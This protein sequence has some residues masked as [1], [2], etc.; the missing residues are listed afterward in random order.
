MS[1]SPL[2]EFL[3][4]S[5]FDIVSATRL[6]HTNSQN[7]FY[8]YHLYPERQLRTEELSGF[9][10]V[11]T[12]KVICRKTTVFWHPKKRPTLLSEK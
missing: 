2:R 5:R 10:R 1:D 7:R 8:D 11:L 4:R 6:A 3:E 12:F 9:N